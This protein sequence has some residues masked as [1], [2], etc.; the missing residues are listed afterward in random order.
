MA[1]GQVLCMM[2]EDSCVRA[3]RPQLL[4][5]LTE[6]HCCEGRFYALMMATDLADCVRM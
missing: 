3:I 2:L 1:E 5:V 6:R 4:V